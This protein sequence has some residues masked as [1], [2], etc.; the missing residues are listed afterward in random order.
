MLR[1]VATLAAFAFAP[2]AFAGDGDLG[3]GSAATLQWQVADIPVLRR[4][5]PGYPSGVD[6]STVTDAV[7]CRTVV[8]IDGEGVPFDAQA[9]GCPA[10]FADEAVRAASDWRWAPLSGAGERRVTMTFRFATPSA[11]PASTATAPVAPAVVPTARTAPPVIPA[12]PAPAVAGT[13][14]VNLV[15]VSASSSRTQVGDGDSRVTCSGH[16]VRNRAGQSRK[17]DVAACPPELADATREVL[18]ILSKVDAP[19][20]PR[21]TDRV[22]VQPVQI[23]FTIGEV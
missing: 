3:A 6:P 14:S 20:A 21:G 12:A 7:A 1:Y 4:V 8:R 2:A 22:R 15:P 17:I 23:A 18:K 16:I 11:A 13:A 10:A 5:S 19:R 9:E